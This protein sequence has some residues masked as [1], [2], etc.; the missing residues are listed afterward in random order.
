M[1]DGG[2]EVV[3]GSSPYGHIAPTPQAVEKLDAKALAGYRDAYLVPN[4]ATLR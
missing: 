3:Y 2:A 4:N 1:L